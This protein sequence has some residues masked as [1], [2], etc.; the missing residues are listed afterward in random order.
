MTAPAERAASG[1]IVDHRV[2]AVAR[3]PTPFPDGN[4]VAE[5]MLRI[6][7]DG[8]AGWRWHDERFGGVTP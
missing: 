4:P 2:G 3:P 6:P 5:F 7:D 8:T 1:R